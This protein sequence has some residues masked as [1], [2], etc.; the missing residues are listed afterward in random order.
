[1]TKNLVTSEEN[2]LGLG[3][4]DHNKRHT[5]YNP[6]IFQTI[7]VTVG[8]DVIYEARIL[9]DMTV[10]EHSRWVY[11]MWDFLG[12]VGGLFEMLQ[13]IAHPG[14][15]IIHFLLNIRALVKIYEFN[16]KHYFQNQ[17]SVF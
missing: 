13:K 11:T 15:A 4:D 12:D 1:M 5:Y 2:I 7:D 6:S 17:C 8:E 10:I 3:F 14:I 9:M 16:T